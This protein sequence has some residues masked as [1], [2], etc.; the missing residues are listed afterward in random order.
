[1]FNWLK[2]LFEQPPKEL[3]VAHNTVWSKFT[4][5]TQDG[6]W[7]SERVLKVHTGGPFKGDCDDWAATMASLLEGA[8]YAEVYGGAHAVCLYKGWVSDCQRKSV[9]KQPK[10][11]K[12]IRAFELKDAKKNR[13]KVEYV[14]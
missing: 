5:V 4:Y 12:A 1:M 8:Q 9:Y 7:A 2:R 11:M 6:E 14:K 10:S 3:V 13:Y